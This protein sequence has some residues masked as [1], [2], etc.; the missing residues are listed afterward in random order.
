MAGHVRRGDG[1]RLFVSVRLDYSQNKFELCVRRSANPKNF[2]FLRARCFR[3]GEPA[4]AKRAHGKRKFFEL[5]A[6]F[7]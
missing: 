6:H 2:Y 1:N 3:V 5:A 4:R 7:R